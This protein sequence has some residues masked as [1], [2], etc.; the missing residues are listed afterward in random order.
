MKRVWTQ[1]GEFVGRRPFPFVVALVG[2]ATGGVFAA[3]APVAWKLATQVCPFADWDGFWLAAKPGPFAYVGGALRWCSDLLTASG[4]S[5]APWAFAVAGVV[6]A[7]GVLR[8]V[9]PRT[10]RRGPGLVFAALPAFV[11]AG[12]LPLFSTQIWTLHDSGLMWRNLLGLLVMAGFVALGRPLFRRLN[13]W[14]ATA[15]LF[16][17]AGV[18]TAPCG[19]YASLGAGV[20]FA[21]GLGRPR[22]GRAWA[23]GV[24][25]F[26]F[27]AALPRFVGDLFY[28]SLSVENA[29]LHAQAVISW[30]RVS[31]L[32][33]LNVGCVAAFAALAA[34]EAYPSVLDGR[35]RR[36]APLLALL[37]AGL[38]VGVAGRCRLDVRP[39]FVVERLAL[40]NR[41]AE[42]L[43]YEK[44]RLQPLR[45]EV[46]WR[47]VAA[48][49]TGQ[50]LERLFDTPILTSQETTTAEEY[51]MDGHELFFA[52]GLLNPARLWAHQIAA[53]KGWQAR[54]FQLLGDRAL[55]TGEWSLAARKYRQLARCP[56][57]RTFARQRL[58]FLRTHRVGEVP[59]DLQ[60]I[61]QDFKAI[62]ED[63]ESQ[64]R[65]FWDSQD[66]AEQA[67]YRRFAQLKN[68]P[69]R[70]LPAFFAA[71]LLRKDYAVLLRN[72]SALKTL[73]PNGVLP[74][75]V[76]QALL[77]ATRTETDEVRAFRAALAAAG[78]DQE[79][80]LAH[81]GRSFLFYAE[82]VK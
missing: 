12:P 51:M 14:A 3:F 58:D 60:A 62:A 76:R 11:L 33:I 37:V 35:L 80:F 75:S 73:Y 8:A 50:L 26:V 22:D 69:R 29:Y 52:W 64:A 53:E 17:V 40:Q 25:G 67:I 74:A 24:A 10:L 5:A 46:A 42:I 59:P 82:C 30:C 9:F 31:A 15:L 68:C 45:M 66:N 27:L 56:F 1:V 78:N 61:A 70:L 44:D 43:D 47:L 71:L 23:G 7:A 48:H 79:A 38:G 63:G 55:V 28:D 2:V 6:G 57:F 36:F 49:R 21:L 20:A 41:F 34:C 72:Q 81:W 65:L 77:V 39:H 18:L 16:G 13:V 54:H 19:F 4:A 32:N